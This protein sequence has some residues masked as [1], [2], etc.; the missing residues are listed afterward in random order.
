[1][2]YT[3]EQLRKWIQGLFD[4]NTSKEDLERN[5]M[6]LAHTRQPEALRAL[7]EFRNSSRAEK[8]GWIDCAIDECTWGLLSPENEREEKD[9]MRVELWQRYEDELL[10]LEGKLEAARDKKKQLELEKEFLESI[11]EQAPKGEPQLAI[12]GRV[13]GM[14]NLSL[15]EENKIMNLQ[16]EIVGQKFLVEQIEKAIES[17]IY[18]KY[19]KDH[20]GVE[21]QRDS[22]AWMS[23]N[24]DEELPF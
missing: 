17:P 4:P 2:D 22:E 6:A 23:E 18:R 24:D 5:A 21:I 12:L 15:L 3:P 14:D 19:G 13:G 10:D 11:A 20:I 7:E 9:Y 8:V 1:M 16:L